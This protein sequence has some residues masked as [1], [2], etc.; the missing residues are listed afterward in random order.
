M[1]RYIEYVH[2]R[3]EGG[4]MSVTPKTQEVTSDRR[5]GILIGIRKFSRK[6]KT[7][8][9]DSAVGTVVI[10]RQGLRNVA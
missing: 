5:E 1:R 10:E 8:W 3:G 7:F 4:V 2:V 9:K 6:A